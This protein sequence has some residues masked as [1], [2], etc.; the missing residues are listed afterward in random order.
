MQLNVLIF[1]GEMIKKLKEQR[2]AVV[3]NEARISN[4]GSFDK[5]SMS[6]LVFL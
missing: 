4:G 3:M 1:F 5:Y 2:R 6:F